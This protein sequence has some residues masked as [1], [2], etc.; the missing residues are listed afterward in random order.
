MPDHYLVERAITVSAPASS[1]YSR[2]ADFRQWRAWS[3]WEG[4]DPDLRRTYSGADSGKGAVYEWAGNRKA[5]EGRMEITDAA[6]GSR[7]QIALDFLKPFKSS[8]ITTFT[9]A[10]HGDETT[11]TWTM[12]GAKTFTTRVMGIFKSMDA[13][14]GPDFEKGLAQ[15]KVV[16]EA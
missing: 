11:V 9:L 2:L 1:V 16:S 15:L 6:E 3:P 10:D 4:L 12:T 5:G 13:M 14:V 8:S 7:L